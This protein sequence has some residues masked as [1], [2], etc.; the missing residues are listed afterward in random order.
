MHLTRRDHG[1]RRD[2]DREVIRHRSELL[3]AALRM[4]GSRAEAEDLLQDAVLRAWVFWERFQPG[5]NGRAWMHRILVNTFINGYRRRRRERE[6][7]GNIHRDCLLDRE[8]TPARVPGEGVSDEVRAALEALAPEFR[9]VILL[10]DVHDRS[11]RDAADAIGCPIG[12]VM[13]RLHRARRAM[14][15]RLSEYAQAEGYAETMDGAMPA[16]EQAA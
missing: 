16:M 3:G 7:L 13:S 15:A 12:T 1:D 6:I 9:Q 5:T 11:Y 14:K 10:V 8:R 4:T 2:F